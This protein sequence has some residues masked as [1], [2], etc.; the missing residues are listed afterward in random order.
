MKTTIRGNYNHTIY[1]SFIGYVVQ[2]I[3]NNFAPLLFLTFQREFGVS[4]ERIAL[5][6]TFNFGV[7][8]LVDF[9]AAGF[10]D[11]IGYRISVV[12]A[13]IFACAGLISLAFLPDLFHDPFWGLLLSV[14]IYAIGGGLIEVL[15]S[16]IV[17]ACPTERKESAMSLLHSFYCWGHAGVILLSTAF[18]AAFGVENWRVL[19]CLWGS[20]PFINAFYFSQVPIS[21]LTEAGDEISLRELLRQKMFWIMVILMICAGACEQG[22]SQWASAFAEA[23]LNVS[24]TVG[25]LAGPCAF[26]LLMGSSR[27]LYAKFSEKLP[28]L[29][30]M[31]FCGVL[32]LISYLLAALSPLPAM[33]LL[34]CA[35]C[36]LS[37]G[38]L[39]PGSFSLA[40]GSLKG[41]GTAMFAFLAL[42]G[43][44]GCS[45]GPSLVGFV[46]GLNDGNMK[47]GILGGI[48]F[49]VLLILTVGYL[50]KKKLA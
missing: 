3:V 47:A 2:A 29:P 24:K 4:L 28:L 40:A 20:V 12:L 35:L 32:C 18:F 27:A 36:G 33:G 49:P 16:P 5:L 34:G 10:V 25:D 14:A 15:V 45:A 22:I 46:S 44:V 19:A 41:G 1:A 30:F 9:L 6:I 21:T 48:V 7:Q 37:V 42:A 50:R 26:A 23:G 39:W 13:Q 43:D 8:L 11:R 38:I 31:G 17:E